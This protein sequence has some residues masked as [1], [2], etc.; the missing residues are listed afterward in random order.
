MTVAVI[1]LST[2]DLLDRRADVLNDVKVSETEL[3]RRVNAEAATTAEHVALE[4]LDEIR[5]LLDDDQ[6]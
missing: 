3:Q 2:Q 1:E 6:Q 5:F 4:A